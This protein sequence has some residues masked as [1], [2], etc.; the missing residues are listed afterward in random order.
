M[1]LS[2][3]PDSV[4]APNKSVIQQLCDDVTSMHEHMQEHCKNVSAS[5]RYMDNYRE[6]REF[7]ISAE[8]Q[9]KFLRKE[10]D[11]LYKVG[12]YSIMMHILNDLLTNSAI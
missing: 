8:K 5:T 9:N 6:L 7:A 1:T 2:I 12:G 10:E 4:Y 11:V 3:R